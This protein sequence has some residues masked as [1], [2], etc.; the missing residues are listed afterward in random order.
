VGTALVGAPL[1][2]GVVPANAASAAHRWQVDRPL[3]VDGHRYHQVSRQ[4]ARQR[5]GGKVGA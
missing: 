1:L 5:F 2:G 3:M 4:A